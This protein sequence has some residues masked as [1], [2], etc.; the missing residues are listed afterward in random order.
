M[1]MLFSRERACTMGSL[2]LGPNMPPEGQMRESAPLFEKP[3]HDVRIGPVGADHDADAAER[4]LKHGRFVARRVA[5]RLVAE[6]LLA[7][8]AREFP[9][10]PDQ[11]GGVV[12][13]L[14]VGLQHAGGQVD[15]QLVGQPASRS[16]YSPVGIGS[17]SARYSSSGMLLSAMA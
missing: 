7:V 13:G 6:L 8:L 11:D 15:I 4:R 9:V 17:P 12:A 3:P 2:R 5:D 16:K 10:G 14:A 1:W